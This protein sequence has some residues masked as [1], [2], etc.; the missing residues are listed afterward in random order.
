MLALARSSPL[1][2]VLVYRLVERKEEVKGRWTQWINQYGGCSAAALSAA[3][4]E[5][6]IAFL[7]FSMV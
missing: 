6:A 1:M 5:R 7:L 2:T 3:A 4:A